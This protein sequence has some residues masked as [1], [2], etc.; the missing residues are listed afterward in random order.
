MRREMRVQM[1]ISSKLQEEN[2]KLR[3]YADKQDRKEGL[4]ESFNSVNAHLDRFGANLPQQKSTPSAI[5]P[6]QILGGSVGPTVS[7]LNVDTDERIQFCYD[8]LTI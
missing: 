6:K 3:E 4:R 7:K 5:S 1:K 2:D 8:R